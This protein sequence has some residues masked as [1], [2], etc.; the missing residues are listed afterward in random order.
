MAFNHI[1]TVYLRG[2]YTF[3][4]VPRTASVP[5]TPAV[6]DLRLCLNT[7]GFVHLG[8]IVDGVPNAS[9]TPHQPQVMAM[10]MLAEMMRMM[11]TMGMQHVHIMV[12]IVVIC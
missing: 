5:W 3:N 11:M 8:D 4:G 9:E 10:A 12:F 1:G 7:N 2:V 6:L